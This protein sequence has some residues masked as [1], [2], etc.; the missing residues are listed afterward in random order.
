MSNKTDP[1]NAA[2]KALAEDLGE[3]LVTDLAVVKPGD[4]DLQNAFLRAQ[5]AYISDHQSRPPEYFYPLVADHM[6][7]GEY[8]QRAFR[9]QWGRQRDRMQAAAQNLLVRRL[10]DKYLSARTQELKQ[11]QDLREELF[12][13]AMP[14][15]VIDNDGV[16]HKE[17]KVQ[18]HS[19]EGVVRVA[20]ELDA[21]VVATRTDLALTLGMNVSSVEAEGQGDG[22][23]EETDAITVVRQLL[24]N[25]LKSQREETGDDSDGD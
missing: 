16:E 9:A 22:P 14:N 2:V 8:L 23:L 24:E 17:F 13:L 12:E 21:M 15:I 25:R 1:P 19:L 7:K 20:K 6:S 18:P 3:Q 11:L 5:V 10:T 4:G